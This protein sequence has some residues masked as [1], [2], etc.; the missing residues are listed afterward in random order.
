MI[1]DSS[2]QRQD[3]NDLVV[4]VHPMPPPV[5]IDLR[6]HEI[7]EAKAKLRALLGSTAGLE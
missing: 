4:S 6:E 1:I 5:P 3:P 7:L 2:S